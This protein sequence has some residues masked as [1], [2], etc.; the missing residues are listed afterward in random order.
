M[1]KAL[2]TAVSTLLGSFFGLAG[3]AQDIDVPLRNWTVPPYTS[4]SAG[5]GLTAMTDVSP[6]EVFVAMTPCRIADTRGLG[7]SSQAGP[8]ELTIATRT[9]QIGG[10]VA[11]VP[12]QCGIPVGADAVSFQF[13][14][15]TPNSAGN[16]VA[17]PAGGAA[18]TISV[19]NWSAGETALGNG[20]IVPISA[21]GALSVRI[22]AAVGSATGHLVIDVNGYFTDALHPANHVLI[23]GN[24][25]NQSTLHVD[26]ASG[27]NGSRAI[28]GDASAAGGVTWGVVGHTNSATNTA[29]GVRGVALS[30]ALIGTYG[31]QGLTFSSC[32][33]ASGVFGAD[34][35][36]ALVVAAD[37]LGSGVRGH[38]STGI[39]VRGFSRGAFYGVEGRKVN[40][41]G[42]PGSAG[43]LGVSDT[44][45]ID[46][47]GAITATGTKSFVEPHP[48]DPAKEIAYVSLEG[49]EAG[50][51]FRGRGR[52]QRGVARIAVP[53]D[54]RLVTDAEGLTV[55]VTPIGRMASFAV[56]R[57]DL[58]GIVI[59]ASRDVEFYYFVNGVRRTF[60]DWSPIRENTS[61]VPEGPDSRM[62]LAYSP[63]QRRSLIA[64]GVFNED[65]TVN[66]A[67]AERLG[68]AR[69]WAEREADSQRIAREAAARAAEETG[70]SE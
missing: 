59:E 27:V 43:R 61:Y 17:W 66:R 62:P 39:G 52:V 64:N 65:G 69:R 19:L 35:A 14:V 53:E 36:G 13:T 26:N 37:G 7:F 40:D 15:V 70:A 2:R 24:F 58:D 51:Y 29:A 46:A 30:S 55:Q 5:G 42:V 3:L 9:F 28:L 57:A 16:L 38:S 22:N 54:F 56:L 4:A 12:A 34:A 60:R 8:P 48:T 21:A 45:G 44:V 63:E 41:A 18:P 25:S 47:V 11:G 23:Y 68:W 50:T 32:C 10:T 49:P 6:G 31:V 20:T 1:T 67:T 33:G